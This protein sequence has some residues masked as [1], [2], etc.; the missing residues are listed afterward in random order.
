MISYTRMTPSKERLE[1]KTHVK[2]HSS[3]MVEVESPHQLVRFLQASNKGRFNY[4]GSEVH[5]QRIL[6]APRNRASSLVEKVFRWS[7]SWNTSE[8]IVMAF[9]LNLDFDHSHVEI[10]G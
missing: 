1:R 4:Q 7:G 6:P 9:Y 3:D 10:P 8:T 5:S 2:N